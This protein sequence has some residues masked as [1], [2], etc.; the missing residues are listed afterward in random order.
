[1]KP[2]AFRY[3]MIRKTPAANHVPGRTRNAV[4]P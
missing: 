2:K 3:L 4:I 1:M